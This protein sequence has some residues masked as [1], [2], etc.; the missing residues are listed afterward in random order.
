MGWKSD[1]I[2]DLVFQEVSGVWA[3]ACKDSARLG[4]RPSS[5]WVL[6]HRKADWDRARCKGQVLRAWLFDD[7]GLQV[8]EIE[9][10]VEPVIR[11]AM[12]DVGTVQFHIASSR[13]QVLF[14][15]TLGPRYGR[16]RILQVVGQGPRGTLER[17]AGPGWVS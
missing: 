12:Y 14:E 4:P 6:E 5:L 11:G 17:T 10:N 7:T 1:W 16:G 15:F 9:D 8:A 2:Y 3:Q 13:K